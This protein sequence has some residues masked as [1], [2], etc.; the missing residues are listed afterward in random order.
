[1]REAGTNRKESSDVAIPFAV[2][3]SRSCSACCLTRAGARLLDQ[4]RGF[5]KF[6][7]GMVLWRRRLL[8]R[9]RIQRANDRRR[10]QDFRHPACAVRRGA[11]LARR[12]LLALQAPRWQPPLLLRAAAGLVT[13]EAHNFGTGRAALDDGTFTS[14]SPSSTVSSPTLQV[15]VSRAR[16]FSGI[17]S[18]TSTITSTVSP[19]FTGARKFSVCEMY[20]APGP[21]KRVPS[22]AEIRLAV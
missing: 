10:L 22:T 14:A 3:R 5:E 12:R 8:L 19:I 11:T 13:A 1:L 2:A 4:P 17:S 9:A 16:N 7:G 6:R 15:Q 20:T 21:G 18:A